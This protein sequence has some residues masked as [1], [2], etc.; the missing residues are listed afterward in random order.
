MQPAS[1]WPQAILQALDTS[2][3]LVLPA[4]SDHLQEDP[5]EGR[6]FEAT[7]KSKS[8]IFHGQPIGNRV[9]S[10]L[11]AART[12]MQA[13]ATQYYADDITSRHRSDIL[14][15]KQSFLAQ[16]EETIQS[17]SQQCAHHMEEERR[18]FRAQVG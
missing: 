6:Q 4:P 11:E 10:V 3:P 8:S 1:Q 16:Q 7:E 15:D 13:A 9:N 12:A 17:L 18:I 5:S 2:T 14:T